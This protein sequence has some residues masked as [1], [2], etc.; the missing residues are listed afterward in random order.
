MLSLR[1]AKYFSLEIERAENLNVEIK[2]LRPVLRPDERG[3]PRERTS[4]LRP[5]SSGC[6]S[7]F[8]IH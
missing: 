1:T 7:M 3:Y 5:T 8:M 2:D 4:Y 6:L